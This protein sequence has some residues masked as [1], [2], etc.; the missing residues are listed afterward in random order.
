MVLVLP[1]VVVVVPVVVVVDDVLLVE[2]ELLW[3]WELW[4]EWDFMPVLG[5]HAEEMKNNHNCLCNKLY[6]G[7][8]RVS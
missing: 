6:M 7:Y 2:L 4:F 1:A 3:L 5:F 8:T